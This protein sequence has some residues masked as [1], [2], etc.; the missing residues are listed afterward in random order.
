MNTFGEKLKALRQE[1]LITQ[2]Q[3]A[4]ELEKFG[5]GTTTKSA[6]SQYENNKRIP[7]T[8]TLVIIARYF[9][10]TVDYLI[11]NSDSINSENLLLKYFRTLGEKQQNLVIA[12]AKALFDNIS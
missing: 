9:N 5:C 11:S 10:V 1:R 6:I 3:F 7:D 8:K 2:E 4:A 12:Y